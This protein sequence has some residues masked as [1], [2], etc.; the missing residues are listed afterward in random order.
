MPEAALDHRID[1]QQ[2]AAFGR[3]RGCVCSRAPTVRLLG[4]TAQRLCD[5]P[6]TAG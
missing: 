4:A 5:R 1:E 2:R 3:R 6:S